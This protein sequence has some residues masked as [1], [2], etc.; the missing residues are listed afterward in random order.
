MPITGSA[1]SWRWRARARCSSR[2]RRP[3]GAAGARYR[4]SRGVAYRAQVQ[5]LPHR[6]RGARINES[7]G[8]EIEVDEESAQ[9]ARLRRDPHAPVRRAFDITSG[10]LRK[11]WTF[12]GGDRVPSQEQIDA[13]L[14]SSAGTGS[15]GGG[16]SEAA[17]ACRSISAA[18]ARSTPS[19]PRRISWRRWQ[20]A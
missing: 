14:E 3:A 16:R 1:G 6:Q 10:V 8:S 15:S 9:P 11:A 5:P 12:D 19:M 17:R 7:A 4:R 2:R 18:S 20:P 13:L